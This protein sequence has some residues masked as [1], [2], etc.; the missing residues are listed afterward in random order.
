M[1]RP[2]N[3]PRSHPKA[4]R[5]E[6]LYPAARGALGTD[7]DDLFDEAEVEHQTAKTLIAQLATMSPDE[8]LYDA[9][10]AVLGEYIRHHVKAREGELFPMVEET[11]LDLEELGARLNARKDVLRREF[12]E[13]AVSL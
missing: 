1:A 3:S 6:I 10:V 11:D 9:K 12:E 7:G 8:D 4:A 5:A 2:K 13:Q